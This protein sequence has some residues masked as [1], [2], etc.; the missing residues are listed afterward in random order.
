MLAA[1][2]G[3]RGGG[4]RDRG[5]MNRRGMA[6][7]LGGPPVDFMPPDIKALFSARPSLP[8][9]GAPP[10]PPAAEGA[11]AAPAPVLSAGEDAAITAPAGEA[12]AAALAEAGAAA[13]EE[14]PAPEAALEEAP[15]PEAPAAAPPPQE[16]PAPAAAAAAAE[17]PPPPEEGPH[18]A[19]TGVAELL[20]LFEA[21]PPPPP[22][23][24]LPTP[25]ERREAARAARMAAAA[26][27]LERATAAWDPKSD[28][29][30]TGNAL[31]TLFV[32]RLPKGI[33][34]RRLASEF[35]EYGEIRDLR[36][37]KDREGRPRGYA[38]I[39]FEEEGDVKVRG[40]GVREYGARKR[41][42]TGPHAFHPPPPHTHTP[43]LPTRQTAYRR[44]EGK[45]IDD[46]RVV[47]D[48]ERGRT[49]RG[50]K[51]R[52]LGGGLGGEARAARPPKKLRHALA[53]V[54]KIY[55]PVGQF[56]VIVPPTLEAETARDAVTRRHLAR[57]GA[58]RSLFFA[59]RAP[60]PSAAA[61]GGAR[62]AP[63][64]PPPPGGF[65][66]GGGYGYGGGGPPGGYGGGGRGGGYGGPPP[67]WG[68]GGGGG[69]GDR[70]RGDDRDRDRGGGWGGGGGGGGGAPYRGGLGFS[71]RDRGRG[72]PRDGPWER[73]APFGGS[74]PAWT[75][76][77]G[78]EEGR[79]GRRSRSRGSYDRGRGGRGGGDYGRSRSRSR[80][81]DRRGGYARDQRDRS[82][83]RGSRRY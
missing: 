6:K 9:L 20:Q 40:P 7:N 60:P 4:P 71:E 28:P 57:A 64:P 48:V 33:T 74:G 44:A 42:E 79:G 8:I 10:P 56:H 45:R 83:D 55:P 59:R 32:G 14:A 50:F 31:A 15:A 43:A 77:G 65:G 67:D 17:A 34:E 36:L 24:P 81:R 82:R 72:P 58:L 11:S 53:A 29:S 22:R 2:N 68:R 70:D 21:G 52:R 76:E 51:P 41:A 25:Q 66:G 78:E 27:A 61:P 3:G 26:A 18:S 13:P 69:G 1:G 39:E 73:N 75:R 47:V 80:S 12:G 23:P 30:I 19:L 38:F 62:Y 16:A 5:N 63:P 46:S 37:V 49:V 54:D 35:K